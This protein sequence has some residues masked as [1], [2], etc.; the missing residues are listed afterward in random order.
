MKKLLITGASS[1]IGQG[2]AIAFAKRGWQVF[3]GGRNKDRL[4]SL[5]NTHEN[6]QPCICDITNRE[7]IERIRHQLPPLDLIFLNAG[8]CEYIDDPQQ[9]DGELFAR[10]VNTN[11]VS[12]GLCLSAW[13]PKLRTGGKL[14]ITSSTAA[15]LPFP[16]A[17]AYG[18][19]KA[20]LSYL[21]KS[22]AIDLKPKDISVTVVHPGF[23]S[24]PLTDKN[25]FA[26]PGIISTEEAVNYIMRGL[27]AG[28]REINFPPFFAMIL[29]LLSW[30]PFSVWQMLM[31][32]RMA[33]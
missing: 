31:T 5:C 10:I 11:L 22:L 28:K 33:K 16:R 30:L 3:A 1:G 20:G 9:F 2:V 24:T 19:S 23:V 18:A 13:L 14:V 12:V 4:L 17:E 8:D 21:A 29:R 27:D 32:R 26:M 25:D 7:D 15:W 6:M